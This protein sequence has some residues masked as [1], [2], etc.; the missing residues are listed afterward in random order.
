MT[1]DGVLRVGA[2]RSLARLDPVTISLVVESDARRYMSHSLQKRCS[3]MRYSISRQIITAVV[4]SILQMSTCVVAQ[5]QVTEHTCGT[6]NVHSPDVTYGQVTDIDGNV[7][8]T[9]VV[10]GLSWFAE[11]LKVTRFQNGDSIPNVSDAAE[12]SALKSAGMC[13]YQNDP[14][15]D[16]PNGKLY[17]YFVGTDERNPCPVG[18]RVPSSADFARLIN[19][20]DADANGGAPSSLPNS[21][22][23][24]LKSAGTSIWRVPNTNATN[25]SGFSAIPNGGRNNQGVFSN[26]TDAAASYWSTSLVGPG[27]GF[28]LELAYPQDYAV[29][30]AYWAQYGACIRCVKDESTTSV[31]EEKTT[32]IQLAP[33]PA[34]ESAQLTVEARMIGQDYVI[35]DVTGRVVLHGKVASESMTISVTEL[36]SGLYALRFPSMDGVTVTFVKQ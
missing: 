24:F 33:N 3:P 25:L 27:M 22:G 31:N 6:P 18:W 11:N 13:S 15:Y 9:V 10:D 29:R 5:S 26:S 7:Y 4:L 1:D 30:N 17:N 34:S 20:Y 36:P 2:R 12:W 16:C 28:F 14:S 21:A 19:Y 8:K 23:G 35:T 32:G